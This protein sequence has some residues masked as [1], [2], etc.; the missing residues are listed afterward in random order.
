MGLAI[1]ETPRLLGAGE[2]CLVVEFADEIHRPSNARLQ[3]LRRSLEDAPPAGLRECVPTYR[4]LAVYFDPLV[5]RR[6]DLEDR[7]RGSLT[8]FRD[9]E[10]AERSVV[11]L[12]VCYG[13]EHGPDL[14]NVA[15]HTGLSQEEV[16]RRHTAR[17]CYCFMLG[18]TPGFPY[19]GGMD[20]SLAT[21]R[22][23]NPRTVIPGGS[24]GIAGK[25]TGVYPMDSPGGWQLIGR[26][27]LRLFDPNGTPPTLVD[28]GDWIRFQRVD[29]KTYVD[30][31]AQVTSGTYRVTRIREGG[32]R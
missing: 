13:G 16:I 6:E 8:E 25:Q 19:L 23:A 2:G 28:A 31:E 4:S 7:I 21:P 18:F 14:A 30:L 10:E 32:S 11:V 26:T 24:V 15:T 29:E 20:E 5:C 22:L 9:E 17:D 27:P 3:L 1:Y 12:P